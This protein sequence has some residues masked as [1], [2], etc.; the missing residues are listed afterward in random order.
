METTKRLENLRQWIKDNGFKDMQAFDCKNTVGDKMKTVYNEDGI[1]VDYCQ[2]WSYL[3]IFGLTEE[4]YNSLSDIL[5]I[6]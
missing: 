5:L 6:C 1:V 4:E 3:E 2:F